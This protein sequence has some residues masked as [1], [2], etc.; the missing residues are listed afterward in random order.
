M[1]WADGRLSRRSC[2]NDDGLLLCR[3]SNFM[4]GCDALSVQ[5]GRGDVD[6]LRLT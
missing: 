4:A 3:F 2:N 1:P 5:A 6:A